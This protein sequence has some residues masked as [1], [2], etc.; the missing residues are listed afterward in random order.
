MKHLRKFNE[1]N[2]SE[3][4]VVEFIMSYAPYLKSHHTLT[5]LFGFK[6]HIQWK[7]DEFYHIKNFCRSEVIRGQ[8]F[9]YL[10]EDKLRNIY[11]KNIQIVKQNQQVF[12]QLNYILSLV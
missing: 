6:D 11:N 9:F 2:S 1:S 7:G 8:I 10:D 12:N 4:D 5:D 3:I